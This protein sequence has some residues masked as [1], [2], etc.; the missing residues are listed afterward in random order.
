MSYINFKPK[1][2]VKFK[3][4]FEPLLQVGDIITGGLNIYDFNKETEYITIK[5]TDIELKV[6]EGMASGIEVHY[7]GKKI[8]NALP[9]SDKNLAWFCCKS[10]TQENRYYIIDSTYYNWE[11]GKFYI[12]EDGKGWRNIYDPV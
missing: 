4:E 12:K 7:Y 2:K 10:E 3:F 5:I 1:N 6:T 11:Y 8:D 9:P